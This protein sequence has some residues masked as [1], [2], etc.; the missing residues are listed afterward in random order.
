M[1]GVLSIAFHPKIVRYAKD[2]LNEIVKYSYDNS[3]PWMII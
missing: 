3:T 2:I 1:T